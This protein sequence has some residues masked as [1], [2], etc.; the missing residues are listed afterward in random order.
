MPQKPRKAPRG[1][2]LVMEIDGAP[3]YE[4]TT[5]PPAAKKKRQTYARGT[6]REVNSQLMNS[7]SA[8]QRTRAAIESEFRAREAGGGAVGVDASGAYISPY[9]NRQMKKKGIDPRTPQNDYYLF[10]K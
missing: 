7:R 9:R 6:N 2:R 5:P 3:Q 10:P 1:Q 8:E 4:S